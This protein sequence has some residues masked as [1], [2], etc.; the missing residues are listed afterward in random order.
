M[1]INISGIWKFAKDFKPDLL[2]LC[3]DLLDATPFSHWL[4]NNHM[5]QRSLPLAK[6]MYEGFNREFM[7]PAR[8]AVGDTC[9][10]YYL[11]G[12]HERFVNDAISAVPNG[13]G[14]WDV[15]LN[16]KHVDAFLP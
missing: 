16:V 7:E 9:F 15:E 10:I 3:G 4:S 1:Q 13:K 8:N 6:E 12:N 11:L 2:L 14:Y 5:R